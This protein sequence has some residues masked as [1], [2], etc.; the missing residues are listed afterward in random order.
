LLWTYVVSDVLIDLLTMIGVVCK[1]STTYLSLTI[2][3]IGNAL[4]DALTTIALA[5]QGYALMG[6]TGTYAG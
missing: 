2:L 5:K 4:P 1:L 3:A 6:L